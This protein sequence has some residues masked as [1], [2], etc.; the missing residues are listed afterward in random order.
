MYLALQ[1]IAISSEGQAGTVAESL[2]K[3]SVV[4]HQDDA[5]FLLLGSSTSSTVDHVAQTTSVTKRKEH[6]YVCQRT[7]NQ[8]SLLW[9]TMQ[10]T[11]WCART[12]MHI[13]M[14]NTMFRTLQPRRVEDSLLFLFLLLLGFRGWQL[15]LWWLV[16]HT[17]TNLLPC[18]CSAFEVAECLCQF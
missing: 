8:I 11:C 16:V 6:T 14:R 15:E 9:V 2:S 10:T 18:A 13:Y 7:W 4:M 17:C 3:P 5:G 12:P 1:V